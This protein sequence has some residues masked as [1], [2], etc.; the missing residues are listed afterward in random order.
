[1]RN[2]MTEPKQEPAVRIRELL[3]LVHS[4]NAIEA[5]NACVILRCAYGIEIK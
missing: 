2:R 3:A 4:V 1:M 5:R